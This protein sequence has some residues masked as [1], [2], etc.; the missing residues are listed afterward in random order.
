MKELKM[1]MNDDGVFEEYDDTYDLTI[2]CTSQ[3]EQDEV[4]LRLNKWIPVSS[5]KMPELI[6]HENEYG[7]EYDE[8]ERVL[9][10]TEDIH[11]PEY[12]PVCIARYEKYRNDEGGWNPFRV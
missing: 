1:I 12:G 8:S 11:D 9:I 5:G 7:D 6:H 2:H 3:E 4:L 10:Y